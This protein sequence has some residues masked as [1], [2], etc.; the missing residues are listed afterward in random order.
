MVQAQLQNLEKGTKKECTEG[1]RV[2]QKEMEMLQTMEGQRDWEKWHL[3]KTLVNEAYKAEEDFWRGKSRVTWL[4][5]GEQNT[6]YFYV[7]TAERMKR[8]KITR[9][10]TEEGKKSKEE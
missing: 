4:R 10:T 8:N 2:V 5:E 6:R 1:N 9:L 3:L 7:V